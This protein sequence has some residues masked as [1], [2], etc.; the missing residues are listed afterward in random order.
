MA[1]L[2]E[3]RTYFITCIF[4][5]LHLNILG[6][7][8]RLLCLIDPFKIFASSANSVRA[9]PKAAPFV[10]VVSVRY[11]FHRSEVALASLLSN[12]AGI[13]LASECYFE[14]SSLLTD[15]NVLLVGIVDWGLSSTN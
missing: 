11:T 7:M 2:G 5:C 4:C 9:S 10:L 14:A 6:S 15:V 12:P 3:D 13:L 8:I 1:I